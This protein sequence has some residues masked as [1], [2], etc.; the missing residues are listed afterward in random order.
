M[1]YVLVTILAVYSI[2][3]IITALLSLIFK[4]ETLNIFQQKSKLLNT[5]CFLGYIGCCSWL[6]F[7]LPFF[8]LLTFNI[9]SNFQ[10]DGVSTYLG[11]LSRKEYGYYFVATLAF[12]IVPK[13]CFQVIDIANLLKRGPIKSK[14]AGII[15]IINNV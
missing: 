15:R 8:D 7:V 2:I 3:G 6:I 11:F 14:R 12:I 5:V 1:L 13:F 4:V 9:S 10:D